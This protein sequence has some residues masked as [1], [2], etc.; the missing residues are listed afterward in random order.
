MG[1]PVMKEALP[2]PELVTGDA[3]LEISGLSKSYGSGKHTTSVLKDINLSIR[4]GEFVA[5]VGFSGSGKT[6]L[7][8]LIAGLI[9]AD[10]GNIRLKGK[11]VSGPG[12]D[13]GVVFQNYSLMPWMRKA[14]AEKYIEMVGL[15]H[16][17]DRR[18]AEL[19]GGMRQ[20]VN[21][22][23]ALSASPEILLLDEP[24]SALDALTRGNLQDEI[25]RIWE[26][27][28]KTVILIT[29]DGRPHH[30]VESRAGRYLWTRVRNQSG[31]AA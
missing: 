26:Q 20:R 25:L 4:E 2:V 31:Q 24:L 27:E 15:S 10:Q 14:K 5:I 7:I 16:A 1:L 23:R 30:P 17:I 21:V 22:A 9:S 6:T 8:S 19:S 29:N 13:R 12:P 11:Q 3:F 28:K 18:P